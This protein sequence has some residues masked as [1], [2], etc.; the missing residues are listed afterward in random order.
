M[1]HQKYHWA[2]NQVINKALFLLEILNG[3]VLP[4]LFQL[5]K[6]NFIPCLALGPMLL[7]FLLPLLHVIHW[8]WT[9][10]TPSYRETYY[11]IVFIQIIG[12]KLFNSRPLIPCE[13][14][15]F[16]FKVTYSHSH[17][18]KTAIILSMPSLVAQT[19]THLSTMRE[20]RVQ[21]L[22]WKDPLEKEMAI[23][24]RTIAWKIPWI[25][26]PGRLQPMGSQRVYSLVYQ[27]LLYSS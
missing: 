23:H 20:T 11:Y 6:V 9:T 27:A 22:G 3:N 7:W 14:F 18:I 8:F 12:N 16:L 10:W 1:L 2:K 26:E 13:K 17:R 24:S 15:P 19:V 4:L 5:L 21:S 25:E